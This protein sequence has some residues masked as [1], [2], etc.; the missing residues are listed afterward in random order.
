[1]LWEVAYLIIDEAIYFPSPLHVLNSFLNLIQSKDFLMITVMSSY[2]VLISFIIA[3]STAIVLGFICGLNKTAFEIFEPIV[4]LLRSTPV[5]SVIIL[6][7]VWLPSDYVPVFSGILMCFPIIF[8]NMVIGIR[9]TDPLLIEMSHVYRVPKYRILKDVYLPSAMSHIKS[10]LTSALGLS[11]KVIAAS[12][13]LSLP[14]YAIGTRLHDS[15]VYLEI[16]ELFAWTLLII[17]MSSIFNRIL[18]S[19]F[20][21]SKSI[22]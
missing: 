19:L 9:Q 18:E 6:A 13:V 1:M 11:W 17:L 12:E 16:S 4:I 20:Q 22:R 14:K 7:I 21:N 5:I 3:S 2:R 15:K 10:G 8:T